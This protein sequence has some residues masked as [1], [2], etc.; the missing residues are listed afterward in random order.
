MASVLPWNGVHLAWKV[1]VLYCKKGWSSWTEKSVL[2]RKR[3]CQAEKSVLCRK[4]GVIFKLENKDG[5][6]FFQ[7]VREPGT[8]IADCTL[9]E[10][11]LICSEYICICSCYIDTNLVLLVL[12]TLWTCHMN[13]DT[14]K[15]VSKDLSEQI[16]SS[17][18]RKVS[19]TI[20]MLYAV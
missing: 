4:K 18:E 7:W 14:D 8:I 13:S 15:M 17:M 1:S 6:H 5:Y 9:I 10:F 19:K 12:N 3:G 16:N 2:S 20:S 11:I